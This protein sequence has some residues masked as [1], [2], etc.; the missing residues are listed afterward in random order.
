MKKTILTLCFGI[1][2]IIPFFS[3]ARMAP[4]NTEWLT[5]ET[6]HFHIIY[7]KNQLDLGRHYAL[8][9]ED[10]FKNLN[11]IFTNWPG[12]IY[13]VINDHT[14]DANGYATV[15]PYSQVVLFPVPVPNDMALSEAGDWTRELVTHELTHIAQ[16]Y[17]YNKGYRF[18]RPLFGTVIS[19]NL[20][21]P[22]WWKEGMAVEMETRFSTGGRNK[23]LMQDAQIRS[24]VL[25]SRL[26]EFTLGSANESLVTW[27]YGTRPYFFGS[28][29]MGHLDNHKD[30][31]VIGDIV[32]SQSGTWPFLID[33]PVGNVL[34][35]DMISEYEE[36]LKNH[37]QYA[38]DQLKQLRTQTPPMTT[39]VDQDL[40]SSRAPQVYDRGLMFIGS[41]YHKNHLIA[42]E[43]LQNEEKN[44]FVKIKNLSRLPSGDIGNFTISHDN[45]S[46][47][48]SKL[49]L[50]SSTEKYSDLF[51]YNIEKE[52]N[53]RLTRGERG[54]DPVI[55]PNDEFLVY[56]RT[57]DGLSEL[58]SYHLSN[59]KITS[60]YRTDS[61]HR[62]TSYTFVD[63]SNLIIS[64]RDKTGTQTLYKLTLS[65]SGEAE[66]PVAFE[67]TPF[68]ATYLKYINSSLYFTSS[69]NGVSNIY[70]GT[71][72]G[73]KLT[74]ITP[75]THSLTGVL[76]YDINEKNSK[77]YYTEISSSGP[78]V[79]QSSFYLGQTLPKISNPVLL[80]Y[81]YKPSDALPEINFNEK[82]YSS[83]TE[84]WP[85]YWIPF[86]SNNINNNGLY[87]QALTS[88]SDP[89]GLQ[90]YSAQLNYDTAVE[91]FGYLFSYT[92]SVV[93]WPINL[94]SIS[95]SNLFGSTN[96]VQKNL[97]ALSIYPDMFTLSD[98]ITIAIGAQYSEADSNNYK[99]KHLGSFLT[100]V[101][102]DINQKP[103]HYYPIQ[104]V[105][106]YT[107]YSYNKSTDDKA[108]KNFGNYSQANGSLTVYNS[109]LL[110]KHN[111]L[112]LKID[113][114][115]TFDNVANRFGTS[116]NASSSTLD[117]GLPYYS[118]RG[119]LPGQFFGTQMFT[120]NA[121]YR[122][123][124]IDLESGLKSGPFFM[125]YLT[126]A[127]V[128]DG[129]AVKGSG[130][131]HRAENYKNLKLTDH[132][133]SVGA[134]ARLS[135]TVGYILPVNLIFGVYKPLSDKFS[136]ELVS[137][138]G[139]Q[140]GGLF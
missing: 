24:Y 15:F 2:L 59:E 64:I 9:A 57:S 16:L 91:R 31:N 34:G 54:R 19:P 50:S 108:P 11:T 137:G 136:K 73:L 55:S 62:I 118:V 109:Y 72:S 36:A 131:D 60:L 1:T 83:W 25:D 46:I 140:M 43:H 3:H 12:K 92:N 122:F 33:Q 133:W 114:L 8:I 99:A 66:K 29:L 115:Y 32:S 139:F 40:Y 49:V 27:P 88:G 81:S 74:N 45:K 95:M 93:P 90:E 63:N 85:H 6:E 84:L 51:R 128:A 104:G 110:P 52:K 103:Y 53:K 126:G 87:Y 47:Y 112:Y 18:L 121:E 120:L 80:R 4:N 26:Q 17:P 102:Q 21:T 117:D 44:T 125:K 48:Y 42:Y 37:T 56:L 101:Y 7:P 75:I 124:L 78:R 107:K 127:L 39:T 134:E 35:T 113:G 135:T 14:D 58:K 130:Y 68:Q 41:D 23:S 13:L 65:K 119:Y 67:S 106:L 28:I 111:V 77:A 69:E 98:S 132:I 105:K 76:S 38:S 100:F 70:R 96:V 129:L 97:T 22:Q 61:D 79:V 71:L 10:S 5:Q 20:L 82:E 116:N 138:V 94:T 86:I 30:K 89:L 123:P